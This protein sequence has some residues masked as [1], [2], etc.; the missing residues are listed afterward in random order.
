MDFRTLDMPLEAKLE[1]FDILKKYATTKQRDED[2][3]FYVS[4][5]DM[6]NEDKAELLRIVERHKP[7]NMHDE[8]SRVINE[9]EAVISL[10]AG[11]TAMLA[12]LKSPQKDNLKSLY[13]ACS[14]FCRTFN[15][16]TML[17]D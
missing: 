6:S 3:S 2:D 7:K 13:N 11:R 14:A 9:V 16:V 15:T 8:A 5:D 4:P 10:M 1:I 12:G 17:D